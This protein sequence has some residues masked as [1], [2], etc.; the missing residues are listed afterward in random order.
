[1]PFGFLH[2]SISFL[3]EHFCHDIYYGNIFIVS[4]PLGGGAGGGSLNLQSIFQGGG[5]L[6]KTLIFRG[7]LVG[8]KRVTIWRGVAIFT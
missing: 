1:M 2:L 6:D 7:G 4:T 8:K 5:G 3:E